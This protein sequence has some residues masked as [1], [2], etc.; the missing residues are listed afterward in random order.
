MWQAKA[1]VDMAIAMV[2][3]MVEAQLVLIPSI[4]RL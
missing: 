1:G 3:N 4:V 2:S